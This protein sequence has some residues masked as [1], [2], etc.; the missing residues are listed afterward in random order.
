M[1]EFEDSVVIVTGAGRGLGR[2]Y[3][4]ELARRGAA[5][6]V[7][8][9]GTSVHGDGADSGV[10]AQLVAEIQASGGVA[11]P[12]EHSVADPEGAQAVVATALDEFGRVDAVVSN[13]GIQKPVRFED[14][15]LEDW[16]RTLDVHLNGAFYVAQPAFRAMKAQGHGRFVFISSSAGAFGQHE[17]THYAAAKTGLWGLANGIALEGAEHGI[18]AN[19]VLPFGRSRMADATNDATEHSDPGVELFLDTIKPELVVPIVVFLAGASCEFSHH[20]FSAGAGR[21][22]WVFVGLA[23]GWYAGMGAEPTVDD[24]AA[25]LAEIS[26]LEPY[27][28][29]MSIYEE[30]AA[31]LGTVHG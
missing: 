8:D 16:R 30:V 9:L 26:R 7:N 10:A 6:V 11:V 22:A 27:S 1:I 25:H 18:F 14:L 24:V 20:I 15:T 21:F 2:L 19:T 31:L 23:E 4:L 3:A 28:V 5:V 13:A 29:P 12:S 17:A